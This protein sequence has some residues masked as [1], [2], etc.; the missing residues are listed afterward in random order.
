MMLQMIVLICRILIYGMAAAFAALMILRF[1]SWHMAGAIALTG[2]G[3]GMIGHGLG[4]LLINYGLRA[5]GILSLGLGL[6]LLGYMV[7]HKFRFQHCWWGL[8]D[9]M[10][11]EI[12]FE[13]R[14]VDDKRQ[15][16]AAIKTPDESEKQYRDRHR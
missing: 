4:E 3:W 9:L 8:R 15:L 7:G 2:F 16:N 11:G 12:V 10:T 6:A 1:R 13:M 5:Y 14:P